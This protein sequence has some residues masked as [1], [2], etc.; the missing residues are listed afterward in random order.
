MHILS[1][2]V[3]IINSVPGAYSFL[4][5]R[6]WGFITAVLERVFLYDCIMSPHSMYP[7]DRFGGSKV[8]LVV[9]IDV[10]TTFSGVSY[11][12]LRPGEAPEIQSVTK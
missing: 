8:E 6:R 12:F 5:I 9:G 1:G 4:S 2:N 3:Y 7:G 11:A 10:G